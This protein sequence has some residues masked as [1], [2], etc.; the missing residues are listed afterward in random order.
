[1]DRLATLRCRR[2]PRL[3]TAPRAALLLCALTI[4]AQPAL[5]GLFATGIQ[6]GDFATGNLLA[7][8]ANGLR[9]GGVE[10]VRQ[11]T[12]FS[13]IP[14]SSEIPF[15]NGPGSY[16]ARLRS[17]GDGTAASVA[18]LT[19]LP[20]LPGLSDF[21]FAT[22]SESEAVRLE[23]LFLEPAA[24]V[25]RPAATD[26]QKRLVLPIDETHIDRAAGFKT[27]RVPFPRGPEHPV[28]IQFRQESLEP[29]N[30]Y[31]TL[32]TNILI[33]E[34]V[35]LPDRDGDSIPDQF[36]NCVPGRNPNQENSDGDRF[37]DACDNCPYVQNNEQADRDGD[38][39][40]NRCAIDITGDGFTD[41]ADVG[42]FAAAVDG[43][44]NP[45]CD[46]D[47]DGRVALLDLALFARSVRVGIAS[48]DLWDFT[49]AFVDHSV[50][51]GFGLATPQG[52]VVSAIWGSDLIVFPGRWALMVRSDAT[53][54]P[55]AEG[56]LTSRP[57][58]PRGPRLTLTAVSESPDVAATVRVLH[59][60][61]TPST[62]SPES[63]L[64][65][66]PLRNDRPATGPSA[67]FLGQV[68][69]LNPWFNAERPLR[70]QRI[71][72]QIRQHTTRA[73]SGYFTLIGD[74]RTGP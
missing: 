59:P 47:D 63:I 56:V 46:F 13:A 33:G 53:G 74:V 58:V 28:K 71:Q 49:W 68:L 1:M 15:P 52:M 60:T 2:T 43:T 22:F 27:I 37:G 10:V 62:P 23:L 67:R 70:N 32:I 73:G 31:F 69:D 9:G 12:E 54:S 18:I 42:V 55:E 51:G 6:N 40:G 20:F 25:L 30:G 57:F 29:L 24:D 16:A 39:V 11:G 45:A 50:N 64:L 65:D 38:G 44:F 4:G 5:A 14:G 48:D 21:T 26:V 66:V 34:P 7:F 36:D 19:T 8:R 35:P 41:E 17:R 61:R 72:V 3:L